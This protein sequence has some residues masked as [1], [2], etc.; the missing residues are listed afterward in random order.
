MR[1]RC[2]LVDVAPGRMFLAVAAVM[3]RE[4][5]PPAATPPQPGAQVTLVPVASLGRSMQSLPPQPQLLTVLAVRKI[6]IAC[7]ESS[8]NF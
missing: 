5:K 4:A 3:L 8:V 2:S 1:C 6:D 7:C